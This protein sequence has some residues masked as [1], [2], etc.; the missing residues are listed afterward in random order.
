MESQRGR[1][2]RMSILHPLRDSQTGFREERESVDSSR[3][4][5][6]SS[7]RYSFTQEDA[8]LPELPPELLQARSHLQKDEL[9]FESI[10]S[11]SPVVPTRG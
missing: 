7:L 10:E 6:D 8:V 2:I 5:E 1:D 11:I 3:L 4:S 9:P